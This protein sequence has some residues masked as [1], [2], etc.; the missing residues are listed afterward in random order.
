MR[1]RIVLS[2]TV[3]V[4]LLGA[5]SGQGGPARDES[6]SVTEAA[7]EGVVSLQVGDCLNATQLDEVVSD[8]PFIPCDQEHDSEV[9]ASTRLEGD[10]YPGDDEIATTGD[11]FCYGQFEDFVGVAYEDSALDY[12]PMYPT[13]QGWQDAGDREV[14]CL[15]IDP[16]GGVTGTLAGAGR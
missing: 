7:T 16:D 5:C 12:V 8:V 13:E 14:L 15:V 4:A 6:G 1:R 10:A 11:D 3:T 9:F 2:V